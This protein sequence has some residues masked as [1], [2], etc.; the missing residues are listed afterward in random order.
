LLAEPL[1]PSSPSTTRKSG[2]ELC[3][4][5]RLCDV[6]V[7]YPAELRNF[8][9]HLAL[10]KYSGPGGPPTVHEEWIRNLLATEAGDRGS[11][12]RVEENLTLKPGAGVPKPTR[13]FAGSDSTRVERAMPGAGARS[14]VH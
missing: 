8:L 12:R 4:I 14:I 10:K 9:M 5:H 11:F 6:N 2:S 1:Q 7:P 13:R 3:R